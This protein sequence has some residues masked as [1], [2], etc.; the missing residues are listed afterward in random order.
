MLKKDNIFTAS[1][2]SCNTTKKI[3]KPG[4]N[5]NLLKIIESDKKISYIYPLVVL[6]L[7]IFLFLLLIYYNYKI[8]KNG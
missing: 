7:F 2:T 1:I 4:L 6:L 5:E 8:N 3:Q